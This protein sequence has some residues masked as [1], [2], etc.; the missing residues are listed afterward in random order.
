MWTDYNGCVSNTNTNIPFKKGIAFDFDDTLVYLH[1]DQLMPSVFETLQDLQTEHHIVIFSNQRGIETKK[2]SHVE[3]QHRFDCFVKQLGFPV[4]IYY[5]YSRNLFRKP[6]TGMLDLFQQTYPN[7]QLQYYCGDACGRKGDFSISDLYFANNS[8]LPFRT[9]EMVFS[10]SKEWFSIHP[11]KSLTLYSKDKYEAGCLSNPRNLFSYTLIDTWKSDI[12]VDRRTLVV[13]V[14][15]PGSGKT[16]LSNYLCDRYSMKSISRDQIPS[17]SKRDKLFDRFK[18]DSTIPGI[19]IDDTNSLQ[20]K[21]QHWMSKVDDTWNV[22]TLFIN[23]PKDISFYLCHYRCMFPDTTYIPNVAIHTY[24]KR[25][26]P[27]DTIYKYDEPFVKQPIN[28][29]HRFNW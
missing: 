10:E 2:T 1:T 27:P 6:Y 18:N 20:K 4:S 8:K 9:P 14:G 19:V 3:V 16:T 25:L 17:Q 21:R 23:I 12:S 29:R 5:S 22:V 26:E 11:K 7:C 15:P 13:M 24:Y 28:F